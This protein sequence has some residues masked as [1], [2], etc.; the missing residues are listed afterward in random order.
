MHEDGT[1]KFKSP[2]NS[3]RSGHLCLGRSKINHILASL[4]S[5]GSKYI[6]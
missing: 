3:C 2:I 4:A 6:G 5:P 1:K